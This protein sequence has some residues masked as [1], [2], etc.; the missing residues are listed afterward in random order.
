M[1]QITD[2]MEEKALPIIDKIYY[3]GFIQGLIHADLSEEAVV[4]YLKAD[5]LYL[6]NFSDIYALLLAKSD[7]KDEKN[8][9]L[10]QINFVL[11]EEI[12]AHKNLADY[13]GRDYNEIIKGG[14]WYPSA[15][16]YIK[17]MYYNAYAFGMAETLSAMAPCPWIYA[18]IAEKILAENKL[19]DDHPLKFWVEFYAGDLAKDC[20]HWYYR[21]INRLA[22]HMSIADRKR[23]IKNFLESCKHERKF[24]NMAYTQECWE[25]KE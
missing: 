25:L 20:L 16:H 6:A 2:I 8:F 1:K 10:S 23:L 5:A 7:N 9:F 15:D 3:D 19:A 11:N 24:F 21:I 13:I 14:E 22:E 4:H 18:K 17:H 12:A